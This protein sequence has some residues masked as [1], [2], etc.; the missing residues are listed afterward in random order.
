[1]I[2]ATVLGFAVPVIAYFW[3]I[4]DYGV[5]SIWQDQWD[6]I[7][8]IAHPNLGNL[9]ALHND[10]RIFFP[11][12]VVLLLAHTTHFNVHIE[13]YL[14]G[15]MLVLAIGLLIV[16]A[17]TPLS[18]NSLALLLS[19][20][21]HHAVVRTSWGHTV[22]FPDGVVLGHVG[23]GWRCVSPG[24]T[25]PHLAIT[26]RGDGPG[27]RRELFFFAGTSDLACR[28]GASLL[29]QSTEAFRHHLARRWDC[30]WRRGTFISFGRLAPHRTTPMS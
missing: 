15:I 5:N 30:Y 22:G 21:H 2:V 18:F 17:Q 3:L 6:D 26:D 11:N 25:D 28:P 20:G 19:C 27:Y 10:N 8:V 4:H 23:A 16:A 29:P 1:M 13:D 7:N 14:S 12:L 24:R 9:W